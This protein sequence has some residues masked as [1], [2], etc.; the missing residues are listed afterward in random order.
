MKE[1][2][3]P[4]RAI[5]DTSV[6]I[7]LYE[8]KLLNYLNLIY[9]EV[10]VPRE[11]EREF[12]YNLKNEAKKS[13]RFAFLTNFYDIHNSWFQPCNEYGSDIVEIYLT[14][15]RLDRGEAEAFAQN[16]AL[17]TVY[18]LLL[19]EKKGRKIAKSEF[20]KHHGV[21]YILAKF[22]LRFQ[23]CK[24]EESLKRLET[25][26]IGNFSAKIIETVYQKERIHL[27]LR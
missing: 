20:I 9:Y 6:L 5:I 14:D 18:E 13:E 21:L 10:R 2:Q 11:V 22:D 1:N 7:S 25:K 4:E 17:G 3:L 24:Y 16:Q 26:N 15:K 19:D 8:L 27:G 23:L 12:L